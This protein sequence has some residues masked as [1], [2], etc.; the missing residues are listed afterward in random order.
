MITP[1][2][3]GFSIAEIIDKQGVPDNSDAK[4]TGDYRD[5]HDF[6]ITYRLR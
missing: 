1:P 5:N 4:T 2:I 3:P 6:M